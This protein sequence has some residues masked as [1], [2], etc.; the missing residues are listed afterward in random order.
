[1]RLSIGFFIESVPFTAD[2]IAGT[3][4]LGGSE[5]ACLG[6][7]RSLKKR[8]HEVHIFTTQLA[9]DAPVLDHAGVMWH[10]SQHLRKQSILSDWDVFVALRM[11]NVLE[12][13]QAKFR[14]LWN[15]DLMYGEPMKN[16]VMGM[17]WALDASIYVSEFHRKQWEGIAHE[18]TDISYVTRN[19]YDPSYVPDPKT[20]TKAPNRIIHISRPERGL[21]PLLTMWPMLK[22]KVP[23]AELH[24][25]RYS[26]MYDAQGWGKV[27]AKFDE[28]VAQVNAE[29]GGI[30]YLGELGKAALYK[31]IAESAVMWYP[32]VSDFG[33]TSC[34]AAIESQ[35][36]GTPFVGSY[37]GALPETVPGG[38]LVKGVAEDD[39]AYHEASVHAVAD[40]LAGCRSQ[41]FAY[42]QTIQA[43]RRHVAPSYTYDAIAED[44]ERWLIASFERRYQTQ[45]MGVLRRCQQDDD[46][47][48]AKLIAEEFLADDQSGDPFTC[49]DVDEAHQAVRLASHIIAGKGQTAEQYGENAMDTAAEIKL[50]SS[51]V[52]AVVAGLA[53]AKRVLD[54]A[55][56]N[57]TFAI[58]LAKAD[59]ERTVVGVDYSQANV[60]AARKA[61]EEFGVADRVTFLCEAVWDFETQQP[62][63]WLRDYAYYFEGENR[64]DGL[65]C[66]EFIEHVAAAK[67]LVDALESILT[68]GAPVMFSCP[69][70]PASELLTR[71]YEL[72]RG[73]V[74]H[75]R[76]GDVL[77]M[78]GQKREYSCLAA[79]WD[80]N[81]PR[82]E[83]LGSWILRWVKSDAPT[84]NRPFERRKL[85][86][87][88]QRLSVGIIT[89]DT[90]DLRR[91]LNEVWP[92]AHEIVIGDCGAKASE[93]AAIVAEFPR[94]TRVVPV[95]PVHSLRGGFSEARNVVLN[96]CVGEWFL[97]IDSDE[98]LCGASDLFKY[99]DGNVV[100]RGFALKQQHLHLDAPMGTDTPIRL[101]R[102][103]DDI[104]FY[105]CIH[106]QPQQGDCNGDILPSLQ[107]ND[108]QLAH[109]GYL[110]ETVRRDKAL[111]RNLPLLVR[112]REV[113]PDR[114]LGNLLVLR[115]FSNMALW[116]RQEAGGQLTEAV[117]EYSA[118]VIGLF[119]THF[120][121]PGHKF[122]DLAR[123]FYEMAL[124]DVA[125]AI[126][127]EVALAGAP[128]G[129]GPHRATAH[130][131]WVREAKHL[132]Q[133]L[134]HRLNQLLQPLEAPS[135]L[136]V[137]PIAPASPVAVEGV[138]V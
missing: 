121:D 24:L 82:G 61:A 127:V 29:V 67:P 45:K 117:K 22:A 33:E 136:D 70:G 128:G 119:E 46:Q 52:R 9:A 97:W 68:D 130:R 95:G 83:Q 12:H 75:F 40:F 80:A 43:G 49:Q 115:D 16:S 89:N 109:T 108:A 3:G 73:H 18:L 91:C 71:D 129:M 101:F 138:P 31:A 66:G 37:K 122:H 50:N 62:S 77:A 132:R 79:P 103:G 125:G 88:L 81:T 134:E 42:R 100:F 112:D 44:W 34:I 35:A 58:M 86:R 135:A 51:R 5:S 15:Q 14:V 19:G 8:G 1:M 4:S 2:V 78:F 41:S 6:L 55:C 32:G 98:R 131:V 104:Q 53:G 63:Q 21:A 118:K 92:I 105:G 13:V 25:C 84:Y 11:P 94:K 106:E 123:P 124:R 7:A 54:V 56:G 20:I 111:S 72:H 110:H 113:F 137:E 65:W 59:P 99:I 74:H 120:L 69:Y 87:P 126:E 107:V 36:N 30:T 47:V 27:C 48:T 90:L 114:T 102:R 85:L 93:L 28:D 64:F 17:A 38:V 23:D 26:S 10:P 116:S 57:G 96:A 60:D 39:P 133:L 76:A